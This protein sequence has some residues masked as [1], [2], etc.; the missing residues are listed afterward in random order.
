ME[1]RQPVMMGKIKDMN[2]NL[3]DAGKAHSGKYKELT[4][5]GNAKLW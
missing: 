4:S 3:I 2:S 5:I 1:K